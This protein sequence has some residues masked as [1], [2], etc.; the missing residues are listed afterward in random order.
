MTKASSAVSSLHSK[1]W[2]Q[3][4][5]DLLRLCIFVLMSLVWVPKALAADNTIYVTVGSNLYTLNST[6]GALTLVSALSFSTAAI[7]RDVN[8][9]R[10]YYMEQSAPFRVGVYDPLTNTNSILPGQLGFS[11]NRAAMD[12]AGVLWV[13][14]PANGNLYTVNKTTGIP[15][16]VG[17]MTGVPNNGGG[18]IAFSPS[19]QMYLVSLNNLY[20]FTGLTATLITSTLPG[21]CP[22]LTFGDTGNPV[23]ACNTNLYSVNPSTGAFTDIGNSSLSITDIAAI[24]KYADLAITKTAGAPI[25]TRGSNAT[26][27][28]AVNNNGPHSATGPFTITDTLPTGLTFV[29]ASGSGWVCTVTGQALSCTNSQATLA[30]GGSLPN[31]VLTV[32]VGASVPNSISNTASVSS[33]TFDPNTANNSS[34]AVT[35]VGTPTITKSFNPTVRAVGQPS[36]L[37][38]TISNNTAT[39]L[40]N[41][42]FNDPFPTNLV[43]ASPNNQTNTCGGSIT[44]GAATNT[45]IGLTGGTLAANSTCTIT[46]DVTSPVVA[47]FTN[48]ATGV[49][50]TQTGAAGAPSTA[51]LDTARPQVSKSFA[52]AN[53]IPGGQ[54]LLTITLSN[55]ANVPLTGVVLTDTF[56]TSPG[57]MTVASPLTTT[58][59]CS[60]ALSNNVG[61]ALAVGSAGI[62]LNG[63]TIPAN[64]S[65]TISVQVTASAAGGY[66][67]IIPVGGVT[68]TNG[69]PNTVAANA[70]LTVARP[71]ISK[72]FAPAGISTN[73]P[74][75]LTITIT[76]PT[77]TAYTGAAFTDTYPGGVTNTATP[78]VTNSCSGTVTAAANGGSVGLSGGTVPANGS[79]QIT[80]QVTATAGGNYTNTIGA[81]ALTTTNGGSNAS[82]TAAQL[83]ATV[84]PDLQISKIGP[85]NFVQG[86]NGTYQLTANN[87]LGSAA[88]TG[89]ITVT[90]VLPAGLTYV[91]ATG[92]GW[93]CGAV[94]QTVT[95]TRTLAI[96]AGASAP[97]ITLTV[98]VDSSAVPQVNNTASIAG[99]G[100]TNNTNNSSTITT[101]VIASPSIGKVFAPTV[102]AQ[103]APSTLT[104]TLVNPNLSTVLTGLNFSDTYPSGLVN[105]AT[106][107]INNTCGGTVT[108]GAPNGNTIGLSGVSL[109]GASTCTISIQVTSAVAGSYSNT[110]S[111]IGSTN[112]GSGAAVNATLLVAASPTIV[113]S[114]TPASISVGATSTLSLTLSNPNTVALTGVGVSDTFPAGGL[115]VAATPA[116]TNTCGGSITGATVGSSSLSLSG[117]TIAASSSCTITVAVT[118]ALPGTFSNTTSGVSSAEAATGAAATPA[119]LNVIAP[120]LRLVK[121]HTG[122]FSVG[123]PAS[124]NLTVNNT[125]GTAPSAGTITVIDTL[126]AGL[127]YVA[128]GSGGTGW[129]CAAAGQIVTCTSSNVIASGATSANPITI[130]VSVAATA[131]PNV[132]NKATVSGGNEPAANNSNNTV[133]DPTLVL[134]TPLNTFLT[135]GSQTALPGTV[136]FFTHIFNASLTG[137]VAFSSSDVATPTIAG[138]SNVIYRDTNCNAVL[139]GT[140]GSST[141]S[142]SV[143]VTPGS[144]V[145]LVVKVFIPAAAPFDAD[146]LVTIT[147]TFTPSTGP[148][149]TYTRTDLTT[150]GTPGGAGL[151]INKSVKNITTGGTS[152]TANTARPGDTIEY[153]ITYNNTSASPIA[154]IVINDTT[155]AFTSFISAAC[156]TPLPA[157]ISG[158]VVSTQPPL[159][160]AGAIVWTLT[161]SLAPGASG[162]VVFRVQL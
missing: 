155:P 158:C 69:G 143:A 120:D 85:A 10:L 74:S 115:Q 62:R 118:S 124:Y 32:S 68:T 47:T 30:V 12:N 99:G 9:G 128:A 94:G 17:V 112:G 106:P 87:T 119:V 102:V 116:L 21:P 66:N 153:T 15:S 57:A 41:L 6:N 117:G 31:L 113:K 50:S 79:C 45:S 84:A 46:V 52:P 20:A 27:T 48:T 11:T 133:F 110:T 101:P 8:T 56:P 100:E 33:A 93:T 151:N 127:S 146:D 161:G 152:S 2:L 96:A 13:T 55:V 25:F 5:G 130:N 91:S 121:T 81:G 22:G 51:V 86:S 65:C 82:S 61:G 43:V 105:T 144:T 111:T 1:S 40:T 24:A 98:A 42:A 76:N 154:S 35:S 157:S 19:G 49:S 107:S 97:A 141:L 139:D 125:L 149:V 54:S 135:D 73:T 142:G 67:N 44:G 90:D 140:E 136:V 4:W 108:G 71:G 29:S 129:S 123:L 131:R 162:S 78:S 103:N 77:A 26:Y 89:T 53:I 150:V 156:N 72:F 92:T 23:V 3:R 138:W 114:F 36:T 132:T 37:T 137:N 64:S 63:G 148:V 59:S 7:G 28:L 83:T 18:D 145:C 160:G 80:V 70:V 126:P 104:L 75:T 16:F 39:A 34:T 88:T 60:G 95:C 134:D 122:N 147:A 58:N 38:F 159:N 14:D 109:A